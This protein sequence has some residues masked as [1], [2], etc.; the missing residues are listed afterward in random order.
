MDCKATVQLG[1][2]SRGG[3]ARGEVKACDHNFG[4]AAKYLPCGLL[5]DDMGQLRIP[6][7]HSAKTSDFIVAAL[8]ARWQALPIHEQRA[9]THLQLKMDNGPESSGGRT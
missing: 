4:D 7:G 2:F 6:F 5:D 3:L 1:K 9:T 8:E